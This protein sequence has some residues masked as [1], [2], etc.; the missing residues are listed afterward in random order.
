MTHINDHNTN[1]VR[2]GAHVAEA[3]R[4]RRHDY[5][6][7]D[8]GSGLP[9]GMRLVVFAVSTGGSLGVEAQALFAEVSKRVGKAL[10]AALLPASSWA[11]CRFAPFA[12]QA[13]GVAVRRGLASSCRRHWRRVHARPQPPPLPPPPPH[14]QSPPPPLPPLLGVGQ[15]PADAVRP[16]AA[17]ARP[18]DHFG[19]Y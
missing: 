13:V 4:C 5:K 19:A 10:P 18:G 14:P 7:A 3:K 2:L 15:P 9:A 11:A 1:E 17:V 12:R 8:D 16:R 6:L